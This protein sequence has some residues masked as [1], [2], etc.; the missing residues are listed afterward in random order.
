MLE[1]YLYLIYEGLVPAPHIATQKTSVG[2]YAVVTIIHVCASF[3][4]T[5]SFDL[6]TCP[7]RAIK[8][9]VSLYMVTYGLIR[10]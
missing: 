9:I 8:G 3:L 6:V 5:S 2:M 7:L 10:F 1:K 4:L